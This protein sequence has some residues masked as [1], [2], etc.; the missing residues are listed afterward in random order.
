MIVKQEQVFIRIGKQIFSTLMPR[1]NENKSRGFATSV[2]N[3][4]AATLIKMWTQR[5]QSNASENPN[6]HQLSSSFSWA[7]DVSSDISSN[8]ST[9]SLFSKCR[10]V[11]FHDT[12][13]SDTKFNTRDSCV[14]NLCHD[15][16][17]VAKLTCI[18]Q[19]NFEREGHHYNPKKMK[20]T[21]K[22]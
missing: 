10:R 20:K 17:S 11:C 8:F 2:K 15:A 14:S 16:S 6:S 7:I 3:S 13:T 18:H 1:S 19:N 9:R 12:S 5:W 22:C 21:K 4:H